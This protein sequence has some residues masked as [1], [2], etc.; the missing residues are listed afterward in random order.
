MRLPV[1]KTANGE[2]IDQEKAREIIDYAMQNGVNYFDTAY[3]YHNGE[4]ERFLGSALAKYSRGD[5]YLATKFLLPA[6]PNFKFVFQEQLK[7]L[8]TEYVDF[9][10]I[11]AISDQTVSRYLEGG[12][13]EYF[14][15]QKRIGNIRHL[16]FSFHGSIDTLKRVIAARDW[17]FAQ[18]QLNYYDWAYDIA[19]EEYQM[20]TQSNI[21]IMVMEP[22]RGGKLAALP[23]EAEQMLKEAHP[24]WSIASWAFRWLKGLPKIQ[25]VL[26][27]MSNMDQIWENVD[28]FSR[29]S[30]LTSDDEK[31]LFR[32]SE[33]F[34]KEV[35]IP[36]TACR[37]CCD[38]CPSQINIPIYL[39]Y[40]NQYL[41]NG[42]WGLQGINTVN[43]NGLP[44]DCIACGACKAHCPQNIQIS[45][46]LQQLASLI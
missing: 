8:Q 23:A 5:Y 15:E 41:I 21:P 10:L 34:R 6:N 45:D 37:Y 7:R 32:A 14:D 19:K 18:I 25:V 26:S 44:K 35:Y 3:V 27:G 4:S 46:Y 2:Q 24:D 9:Y 33:L 22:V 20:L 29:E 43:S 28:L 13:L 1:E 11:H 17:D 31:I 42:Q 30:A 40:M 38:D 39:D 36:C 16:G 12:C